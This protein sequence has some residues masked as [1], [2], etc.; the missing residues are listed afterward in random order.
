MRVSLIQVVPP[1][2]KP[3]SRLPAKLRSIVLP[4]MTTFPSLRKPPASVAAVLLAMVVP[5]ML[6]SFWTQKPPALTAVLVD[7]SELT[8]VAAPAE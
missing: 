2:R 3:P 7:T 1:A 6:A 4:T 5:V 8:S